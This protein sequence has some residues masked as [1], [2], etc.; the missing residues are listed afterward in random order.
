M[1]KK[2]RDAQEFRE[3]G[4]E[5]MAIGAKMHHIANEMDRSGF[6]LFAP[7]LERLMFLVEKGHEQADVA[8]VKLES[9]IRR[10]DSKRAIVADERQYMLKPDDT[11]CCWHAVIIACVAFFAFV[12]MRLTSAKLFS[13]VFPELCKKMLPWL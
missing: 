10:R 3:I 8:R 4:D 11:A 12:A 1:T 2:E 6:E 5:I 7:H 9:E 13:L